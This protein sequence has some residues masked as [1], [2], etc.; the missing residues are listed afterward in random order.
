MAHIE[1][2][3]PATD[4]MINSSEISFIGNEN[5]PLKILVVGNSI[6]MH[7]PKADIGWHGNW[8]M[9]ASAED[10]DYVHRLYAKLQEHG[11]DAYIRIRQCAKWERNFTDPTILEDYADEQ[12]FHA[13]IVVYRLGENVI[14]EDRDIFKT[15]LKNFIEYIC[16][17]NTTCLFTSMFWKDVLDEITAE[18]AAERGE[19]FVDVALR[20]DADT[21]IGLFEHRGVSL[22]PGDNGMEM[23]AENIFQGILKIKK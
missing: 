3:V 10:K 20:D 16:P 1:N 4:Q 15:S 14:L 13:D 2:T 5:A 21:A 7:S 11:I 8:G 18:L 17:E 23:M 22:H 12:A 9:A 19:L 6:T